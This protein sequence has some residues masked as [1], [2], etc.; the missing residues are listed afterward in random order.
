MATI[1]QTSST[2]NSTIQLH[3]TPVINETMSK[4]VSSEG[5]ASPAA[6]DVV[7]DGSPAGA[8]TEATSAERQQ[9]ETSVARPDQ[10]SDSIE[11]DKEAKVVESNNNL[12]DKQQLQVQPQKL[13]LAVAA[14]S[15]QDR[16]PEA[17]PYCPQIGQQHSVLVDFGYSS[18]PKCKQTL[19]TTAGVSDAP[20]GSSHGDANTSDQHKSADNDLS[21]PDAA[22][23]DA[24]TEAQDANISYV[25]EYRD[26]GDYRIT[27]EPWSGPFDL[28][29]AR[30]GAGE[31]KTS[32][33]D[34]VTVLKTTIRADSSR[35]QYEVRDIMN[36]GILENPKI[37]VTVEGS[38]VVIHSPEII[39]QLASVASYYP[40]IDFASQ[41]LEMREPYPFI[42]HHFDE[43]EVLAAK[44]ETPQDNTNALQLNDNSEN[45]PENRKTHLRL[46]LDFMTSV[47]QDRIINERA[48]HEKQLC[49]FRM[50]WLLFKPGETVYCQTRG[51]LA[52]YV[53]Q[54]VR[55][56]PPGL[57]DL[58]AKDP[59]EIRLWNLNFDGE[60]VGRC[61]HVVFITPF[62][63]ERAIMTLKAFPCQYKDNSDGG[64]HRQRLEAYGKEWYGL[65]TGRQVHYSGKLLDPPNKSCTGRVYIDTKSYYSQVSYSTPSISDIEDIGEGLALCPCEECL[66]CRAHP[67]SG[68][69]WS[70]YDVINPWKIKSLETEGG[71]EPPK[72]R[73]LLCPRELF[74]L[75]LKSRI[76]AMV[77]VANCSIPHT[78][79]EAIR[80]LVMPEDRKT[81]IEALVQRFS[82]HGVLTTDSSVTSEAARTWRA[83]HMEGKGEGQIFLL[84]G[85]PGVGKTF[86]AECIAEFT[87]RALLSLTSGD[88]GTD[89]HSVEKALNKWFTLAEAWGAV[90][91]I[92][93]ADV[94]LERRHI[95]DLK[96]NSLVSVFLRSIEYYRG[97]LFLTTNRV[98]T[99]DDA[100]MSR[101]HVVIAYDDLGNTE[102]ETI[103]R[104]FFDKL[105]KDRQD[106]TVLPRAKNYVLNND[107]MINVGWNGR[108]IRNAF[109]TA[110]ALADYRAQKEGKANE[111]TL[112]QS[113]F[114]HVLKL[115]ADFKEYLKMIDGGDEASRA[116]RAK[117]RALA[118]HNSS[119]GS[120]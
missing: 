68:F 107:G 5:L 87:G 79:R 12:D 116:Y 9:E 54:D 58:T 34:V 41:T 113:D 100:F 81:L 77:D 4:E 82:N 96:R 65:L 10:P 14:P 43:L 49:T 115:S 51:H 6:V 90:M 89:E 88:L 37:G 38:K 106:I 39:K 48:R 29:S 78:N 56:G 111:P 99:F 13:D 47:Y 97:I 11:S 1:P 117:H 27:S 93:E 25:V 44:T 120:R 33:F 2:L 109:Q 35:A 91:L 67:P 52:A 26:A 69:R 108:E 86:T 118:A 21:Q 95:T 23:E 64:K 15:D 24:T 104:Q 61:A 84:H 19:L 72:H 102:R 114:E 60:F 66:G 101:I 59:Y 46:F 42:G 36:D 7:G 74:G 80:S 22:P 85:G 32:I 110:V 8:L 98:G 28:V 105:I 94:Y 16:N 92:D 3:S 73:Y 30:K 18:C 55:K 75:V 57:S 62:E 53:V 83:D 50:L 20:A 70:K 31:K 17:S 112:D 71:S 40:S 63:G 45:G 103:W 76:W 119:K